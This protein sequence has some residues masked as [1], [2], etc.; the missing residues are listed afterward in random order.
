MV[1]S[2]K[3]KGQSFSVD[4]K[5]ICI[6]FWICLS[7]SDH[8]PHQ[9]KVIS[10]FSPLEELENVKDQNDPQ[11]P[12]WDTTTTNQRIL[13]SDLPGIFWVKT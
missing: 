8:K 10:R 2:I 1:T 11:I 5:P 9:K 12:S 3:T 4:L 7:I 6:T 13:Q